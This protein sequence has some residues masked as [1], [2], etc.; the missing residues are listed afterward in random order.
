MHA[1]WWDRGG[2]RELVL[3]LI[4]LVVFGVTNRWFSWSGGIDYLHEGDVASYQAMATA[5]PGLPHSDIGSAYTERF[6]VHYLAGSLAALTRLDLHLVYRVLWAVVFLGLVA[7][8]AATLRVLSVRGLR[9]G[10]AMTLL[11]MSPYALRYYAIV[12]GMLADLVFELGIA[13]ALLG[14][15]S[16]RV[17][18]LLVGAV[19][20]AVARQTALLAVPPLAVWLLLDGSWPWRQRRAVAPALV[21]LPLLAYLGIRVVTSSFTRPFAPR[22]PDDTILPLLGDLPG[23]ASTL[24]DHALHVAAPLLVVL[25]LLATAL[26]LRGRPWRLDRFAWMCLTVGA[27]I[28]L[29]P[30]VI[31]P[32][33]PGFADNEPRI[34]ALGLIPFV[35]ALAVTLPAEVAAGTRRRPILIGALAVLLTVASLHPIYT[36]VGPQSTGQF[37][38]I[39]V[40][41]ALAG[42]AMVAAAFGREPSARRAA[43][44]IEA[45]GVQDARGWLK[46]ES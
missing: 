35:L 24:V 6:V 9:F 38:A 18:L 30:L 1:R 29:Q 8:V 33:Y 14:M 42:A 34:S 43:S 2:A 41:A 20:A 4:P 13:V 40:V 26:L 17:R 25:V 39:Q 19:V 11:V 27:L 5:A 22:I 32:S 16:R 3:V 23:S 37:L 45:V 21:V 7:A 10:I 28:S 46:S 12:P 36:V 15:A 31:S 44:P